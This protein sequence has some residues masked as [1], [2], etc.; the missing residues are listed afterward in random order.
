MIIVIV[1][2]FVIMIIFFILLRKKILDKFRNNLVPGQKVRYIYGELEQ[3]V[4]V[5]LV[6]RNNV[7]CE[8]VVNDKE[9]I[10]SPKWI[11]KYNLYPL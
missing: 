1:L 7:Y 9:P 2:F 3:V 11:S 8:V 5:I 10:V 4:K 6:E